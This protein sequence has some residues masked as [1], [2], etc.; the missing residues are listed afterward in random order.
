MAESN[1][2][3]EDL[4]F[5][6]QA[7]EARGR[8]S[9]SSPTTLIVWAVYCLVCI[10]TYDFVPQYGGRINAAGWIGA[11]VMSWIFGKRHARRTGEYDSALLKRTMLHWFGGSVLLVAATI[12]LAIATGRGDEAGQVSAVLVGFMYYFAGVNFPQSHRFMLWAG[13]VIMAAGICAGFVP[14]YRST[15]LGLIFACCLMTPVV[16]RW[17]FPPK[18]QDGPLA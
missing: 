15:T 9:T 6:R 3:A 7:V 18:K 14:H 1:P 2:I 12:G 13:P 17:L 16:G 11:M 8:Q 10:P 4:R 5:V